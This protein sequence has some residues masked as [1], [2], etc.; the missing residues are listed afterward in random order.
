MEAEWVEPMR[1]D[2]SEG[3]LSISALGLRRTPTFQTPS[4]AIGRCSKRTRSSK[5]TT[6]YASE[7]SPGALDILHGMERNESEIR[8]GKTA[9]KSSLDCLPEDTAPLVSHLL[10]LTNHTLV[11][12]A[13]ELRKGLS[14]AIPH[15]TERILQPLTRLGLHEHLRDVDRDPTMREDSCQSHRDAASVQARR[16]PNT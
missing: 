14:L 10:K 2:E 4:D 1:V 12:C 9:K 11:H 3:T 16:A 15:A 13:C 7:L 8:P 6:I 5:Q